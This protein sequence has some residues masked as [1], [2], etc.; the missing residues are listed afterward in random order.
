[1]SIPLYSHSETGF[2]ENI[3]VYDIISPSLYRQCWLRADGSTLLEKRLMAHRRY[4]RGEEKK[5]GERISQAFAPLRRELQFYLAQAQRAQERARVVCSVHNHGEPKLAV[6]LI[7]VELLE[8][9][10]HQIKQAIIHLKYKPVC[11]TKRLHI[12]SSQQLEEVCGTG[13]LSSKEITWLFRSAGACFIAWAGGLDGLE[14]RADS[15]MVTDDWYVSAT[16]PTF[17]VG[18]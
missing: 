4:V 1:M 7:L 13:D 3:T 12:V 17:P 6:E 2:V 8:E 15:S 10:V 11:T 9:R 5:T 18:S 16:V 14:F